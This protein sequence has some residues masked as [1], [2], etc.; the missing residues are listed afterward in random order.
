MLITLPK[1]EA[2]RL[3]IVN[4][5]TEHP[6]AVGMSY[7]KHFRFAFG[8]AWKTLLCCLASIVHAVFPFL[9]TTYTSDS[10]SGLHKLFTERV[11]RK[12]NT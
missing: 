6:N 10:I 12:S 8:L 2:V 9:L 5:F 11:Y 3:K 1:K 4:K 7:F